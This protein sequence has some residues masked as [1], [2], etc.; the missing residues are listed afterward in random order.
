MPS[1]PIVTPLSEHVQ[2]VVALTQL[3][4]D[5]LRGESR[6]AGAE[7]ELAGALAD[8]RASGENDTPERA[9]HIAQLRERFDEAQRALRA[10]EAQRTRLEEALNAL[11]AITL[12]ARDRNPR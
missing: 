10:T 3:N 11:N 5:H 1:H 12:A 8:S 4:S 2:L 7:I 9:R 6:L